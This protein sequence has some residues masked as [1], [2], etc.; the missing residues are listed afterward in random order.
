MEKKLNLNI[1]ELLNTIDSL[2]KKDPPDQDFNKKKQKLG[3]KERKK[4][5]KSFQ[6]ITKLQKERK[7]LSP[8]LTKKM[9][10]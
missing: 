8:E 10:T 2:E 1:T 9:E 3:W 4:F 7:K 5:R 6:E